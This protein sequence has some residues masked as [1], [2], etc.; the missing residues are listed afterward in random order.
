MSKITSEKMEAGSQEQHVT[1]KGRELNAVACPK[2]KRGADASMQSYAP[3]VAVGAMTVHYA[4]PEA[5]HAVFESQH[6]GIRAHCAVTAVTGLQH[7][8]TGLQHA[9]SQ[10]LAESA[11][12]EKGA[13]FFLPVTVF[14]AAAVEQCGRKKERT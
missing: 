4:V 8:V 5:K 2:K 3:V 11:P 7:A 14:A 10:Q 12:A 1:K 9:V 6:A 13:A